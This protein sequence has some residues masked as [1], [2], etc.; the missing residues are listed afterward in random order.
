MPPR[1]AMS[2][3]ERIGAWM[4]ASAEVRVNRGSTWMTV[5]PRR[6]AST[7]S[8]RRSDGSP[9]CWSPSPRC[10]RRSP[11]P[12]GPWSPRRVQMS[13]PDSGT[14]EECQMRAWFS[15]DHAEAAAEQLL[16]EVV[17]LVVQRGTAERADA[18]GVIHRACRPAVFRRS[19]VAGPASSAGR[20][21]PSPSPGAFSPSGRRAARG[22][23]PC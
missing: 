5:A 4:S 12:K 18:E 22:T 1:N 16:D 21:A 9:P 10:S 23:A 7:R 3:P 19:L 13:S 6:C 20:S 17:F 14:D 2:V 11:G 15:I 8:G